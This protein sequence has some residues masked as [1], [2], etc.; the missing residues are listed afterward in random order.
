M[1]PIPPGRR[2]LAE[3]RVSPDEVV[4]RSSAGRTFLTLL[5][6]VVLGAVIAAVVF[7]TGLVSLEDDVVEPITGVTATPTPTPEEERTPTPSASG[8]VPPACLAAAEYNAT[9][10]AAL[11]D[12]AVGVRDQDA[13]VVEEGLDAIAEIKPEMDAASQECRDLAGAGDDAASD[14]GADDDADED[15]GGADDDADD[16]DA[17]RTAEPSPTRTP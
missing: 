3:V 6:G 9:V 16:D 11:D 15:A 8:D 12:V 10:S 17:G 4:R 1:L 13:L 2:E 7:A 14:D 5:G